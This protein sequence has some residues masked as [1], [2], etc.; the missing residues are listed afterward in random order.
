MPTNII[1]LIP[2][3]LNHTPDMVAT[4]LQN[5]MLG[6]GTH[7]KVAA[8]KRLCENNETP[9]TTP[10]KLCDTTDDIAEIALQATQSGR[11]SEW[12]PSLSYMELR[13]MQEATGFIQNENNVW[14]C[15]R[16]AEIYDSISCPAEYIK[17][18]ELEVATGCSD[19][20]LECLE[21]YQCICSPCYKPLHC[22]DSISIAGQCVAY[23]V[24]LPAL[25]VPIAV[26]FIAACFT[27]L[28]VKSKQ[29]VSQAK[30]AAKNERDL[31]EF[32]A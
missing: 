9:C 20:G 30:Q 4:A 11:Y 16:S 28:G 21:G 29:M 24:F 7:A 2:S 8:A 27:A 13:S 6:V 12:V 18:S 3:A 17:K 31:N 1:F 26:L 25:L 32:I 10:P 14:R 22:V 15:L 23:E 19:A 5:A